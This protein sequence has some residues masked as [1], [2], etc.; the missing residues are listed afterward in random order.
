MTKAEEKWWI[1]AHLQILLGLDLG[2]ESNE[3]RVNEAEM[4]KGVKEYLMGVSVSFSALFDAF[5]FSK[6][7]LKLVDKPVHHSRMLLFLTLNR[8][9]DSPQRKF[10]SENRLQLDIGI[11]IVILFSVPG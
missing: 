1:R 5:F 4:N 6:K 10:R 9:S 2:P 11:I 8:N 3:T 7:Q